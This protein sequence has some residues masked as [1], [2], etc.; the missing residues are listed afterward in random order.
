VSIEENITK[1]FCRA[2]SKEIRKE[3]TVCPHCGSDLR[4]VGKRKDIKCTFKE[5]IVLKDTVSIKT[6]KEFYETNPT[7]KFLAIVI[8][9]ISPCIGLFIAGIS[10]I[11]IGLIVSVIVY[12]LSPYAVMKVREIREYKQR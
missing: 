4:K 9:V 7:V 6:T 12:Y 5:R 10:G 8:S 11:V 2:C 3:D 1:Y